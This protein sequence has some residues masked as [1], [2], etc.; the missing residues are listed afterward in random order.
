VRAGDNDLIGVA[1]DR[2]YIGDMLLKPFQVLGLCLFLAAS[3]AA[4]QAVFVVDSDTWTRPRSAE[5]LLGLAPLRDAVGSLQA[6]QSRRLEIRHPEGE[7]GELWAA[8]LRDWLVALGIPSARLVLAADP[9]VTE[10]I[11]LVVRP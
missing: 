4:A 5:M 10:Q 1:V 7:Q 11:E 6:A 8:E 9:A 3:Q 2:W